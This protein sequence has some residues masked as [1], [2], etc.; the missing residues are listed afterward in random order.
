MST[1]RTDRTLSRLSTVWQ[2]H[3]GRP[4]LLALAFCCAAAY[5]VAM[6]GPML[7]R[8]QAELLERQS[9]L[10]ARSLAAPAREPTRT[11]DEG[12]P[13]IRQRGAD[14]AR[15]VEI[16]RLADV[17]LMRGDYSTD[18]AGEASAGPSSGTADAVVQ[19]H[20]QLPVRGSY[21]QLRRFIAEVLNALPH[22]ALVGLQIDRPD[23]QQPWVETTLR[24][25][26]YYGWGAT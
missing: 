5:A 11:L 13:A 6:H 18:T 9:Q 2:L 20:V 17:E 22:A 8:Q 12:L 3:G 10:R 15:L 16:A 1:A 7:K 4:G 14:L 24:F 25:T 21:A 19:W 26:L 23:T